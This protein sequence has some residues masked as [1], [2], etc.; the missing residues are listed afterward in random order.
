[1]TAMIAPTAVGMEAGPFA[2]AV[3]ARR[4]MAYAA[5][6]GETDP[7]YFDTTAPGGPAAHPLFL[8]GVEWEPLVAVRAKAVPD[9]AA[10][11]GVHATHHVRRHRAPRAGDTLWTTARI[12]A[13]EARRAGT[14]LTVRLD[15]VDATGAAVATTHYGSLFRGAPLAGSIPARQGR[16]E[17]SDTLSPGDVA[18]EEVVGVSATAA[19]VYTECSRIWNPIHTDLAA[20]RA[21]ALPGV[22]LHGTATLAFAV[23]RVVAREARGDPDRVRA[24]AAR[25]T[26]MVAM[27]STLRVRGGGHRG[28]VVVFEVLADDGR[29]VIVDGS[30][31][32]A[33]ADGA[34]ERDT[35]VWS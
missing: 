15:T 10:A 34:E 4:L 5:G 29:P 12:S 20:A 16:R 6:V 18:W 8:V 28:A 26:A 17:H 31:E 25:F 9:A 22:I 14:L 19:H 1:M 23:S 27:P 7:R 21:A 2:T 11:R 13:V 35:A 32:L 24:L 3:D 33:G 30:V